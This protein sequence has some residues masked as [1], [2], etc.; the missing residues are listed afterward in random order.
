MFYKD[1][2][3]TW[4]YDGVEKG[5]K[6]SPDSKYE[7]KITPTIKQPVKSYKE[8]LLANARLIRDSFNEP[9]DLLFSGGVD[10]EVILR[11]N[12]EL[13]IP[14]NV[15][16]FRYENRYNLPD[17][18]HALRICNELNV[19]P[20]VID[21]NLKKFFEND[22][23]DIWKVGH[24][25]AAGRLTH[26]KM[27]DYL[28]NIPIMGDGDPV[29]KFSNGQ[30]QLE[31]DESSHSQSIYS[32]SIQRPMIVDWY[33]YSP[34]VIISHMNHPVMA[35]LIQGPGPKPRVQQ[36]FKTK[37]ILYNQLWNDIT[38]RPKLV[39]YECIDQWGNL[40]QIPE[41]M[42]DFQKQYINIHNM[43][44]VTYEFTQDQLIKKLCLY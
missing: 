24:F 28:D 43:K 14:I 44:V 42:M 21:F 39:G 6:N 15:F 37:Y 3:M 19:K 7:L 8:E 35:S 2:W 20:T 18:T 11:C 33:E 27:L 29:W 4:Y 38:I 13:G 9:F 1:N 32:K 23:Y 31:L 30:W 16:I 12:I 5:P 34:E 40:L 36:Y 22:A 26:M 41:F 25:H 10:S 17:V